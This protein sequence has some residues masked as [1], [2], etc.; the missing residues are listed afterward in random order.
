MLTSNMWNYLRA[1]RYD[2][3]DTF[4]QVVRSCL[5]W[6]Y[7][8]QGMKVTVTI[9]LS[10]SAYVSIMQT[11][12]GEHANAYNE[13]DVSNTKD[14]YLQRLFACTILHS[15]KSSQRQ[16]KTL[17]A[18]LGNIYTHQNSACPAA[19]GVAK[20]YPPLPLTSQMRRIPILILRALSWLKLLSLTAVTEA[21]I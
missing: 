8:S 15:P 17:M 4:V 16:R 10:R 2:G 18:C 13:V 5:N 3:Y 19:R 6:K 11:S 9:S 14:R 21:N 1:L 12:T 20:Q 7:V